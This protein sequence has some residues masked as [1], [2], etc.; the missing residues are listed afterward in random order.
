MLMTATLFGAGPA[1]VEVV[2][3]VAAPPWANREAV[4][5]VIRAREITVRF[6]LLVE[7]LRV[8]R[9]QKIVMGYPQFLR[10][11]IPSNAASGAGPRPAPIR[12]MRQERVPPIIGATAE[13]RQSSVYA[14]PCLR[15]HRSCT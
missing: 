8:V 13:Q 1:G 15:P 14:G 6:M 12:G 10:P 3:V 2:P 9:C 7:L 5:S 11:S 4:N